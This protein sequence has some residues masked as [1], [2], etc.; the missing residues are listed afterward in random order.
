MQ[1]ALFR[2]VQAMLGALLS[3]GGADTISVHI[4]IENGMARVLVE[5]VNIETERETI[6]ASLEE[7]H[8][9][10]R[11][12]YFGATME[13]ETRSNRGYAIEIDIPI[14]SEAMIAV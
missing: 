10:H 14:P 11:L 12:S 8:Y 2:F 4:G 9:Q 5:A 3:E 6:V 7:T 13:T 1:I